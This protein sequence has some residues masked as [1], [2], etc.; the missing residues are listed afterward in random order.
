[1]EQYDNHGRLLY[2]PQYHPNQGAVWTQDDIT[3]LC[4]MHGGMS[5]KHLS[6]ALGRTQTTIATKL[7][8]LQKQGKYEYYRQLGKAI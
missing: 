4:S 3:Y 5:I 1:M 2:N 8:D 6:M 7:Y